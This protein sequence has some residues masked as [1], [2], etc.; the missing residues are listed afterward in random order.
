MCILSIRIQRIYAH[1]Q[2]Q[3]LSVIEDKLS[4]CVPL[5]SSVDLLCFIS[6]CIFCIAVDSGILHKSFRLN[7]FRYSSLLQPFSSLLS[8]N[9]FRD[10]WFILLLLLMLPAFFA[11]CVLITS[12]IKI[13]HQF[14][15]C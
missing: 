3:T 13:L 12:T 15:Y 14:S 2:H 8:F 5:W 11:V 9:W 1:V 10:I 4:S 6:V 7:D